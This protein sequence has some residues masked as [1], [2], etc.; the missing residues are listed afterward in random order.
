MS[1]ALSAM[2]SLLSQVSKRGETKVLTIDTFIAYDAA[3]H[4]RP[5]DFYD[6][7]ENLDDLDLAPTGDRHGRYAQ[8]LHRAR[9]AAGS[10][11]FTLDVRGSSI[12]LE[13]G[14]ILGV[15]Q[16]DGQKYMLGQVGTTRIGVATQPD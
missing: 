9:P 3:L 16:P 11:P 7:L 15:E 4:H 6:G 5:A 2:H 10:V 1:V 14:I 12:D 13:F 8:W